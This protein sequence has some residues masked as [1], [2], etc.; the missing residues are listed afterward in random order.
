MSDA[1]TPDA[2]AID[3][4]IQEGIKAFEAKDFARAEQVFRA[5]VE[6]APDELRAVHSIGVVL[7]QSGRRGEARAFLE[8]YV[9][10]GALLESALLL[11]ELYEEVNESGKAML[12]YKL[13]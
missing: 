6:V 11:G 4:R 12:C 13:V 1:V 9:Q 3:A 5:V 2:A 7:S 10:K 8:P